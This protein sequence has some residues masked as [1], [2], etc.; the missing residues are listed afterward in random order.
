M[1]TKIAYALTEA[2]ATVLLMGT[3]E[4]VAEAGALAETGAGAGGSTAAR[5]ML[6]RVSG[7]AQDLSSAAYGSLTGTSRVAS[8]ARSKRSVIGTSSATR[9]GSPIEVSR[10]STAGSR[11]SR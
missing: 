10:S 5:L 8:P 7:A 9:K 3:E 4:A 11:G 1:A 6:V 2:E